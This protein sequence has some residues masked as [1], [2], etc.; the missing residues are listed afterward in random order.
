ME[1]RHMV[2][3]HGRLLA[4][5]T[6]RQVAI[7]SAGEGIPPTG[8]NSFLA[9]LPFVDHG[10]GSARSAVVETR[11]NYGGFSAA[12]CLGG[13]FDPGGE[14]LVVEL[15]DM[16]RPLPAGGDLQV[17]SDLGSNLVPGLPREYARGAFI[18][19]VD[20]AM[21]LPLPSGRLRVD[22]AA[23]DERDSS[24]MAFKMVAGLLMWVLCAHDSVDEVSDG[25]VLDQLA[26]WTGDTYR[27]SAWPESRLPL[28]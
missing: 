27:K 25:T 10:G 11:K 24:L 6:G 8:E 18:G 26:K 20:A 17:T 22:I 21:F 2:W 12:A 14:T 9:T 7:S 5:T 23:H 16:S 15:V 1:A 28:H 4:R 3:G 13:R 19:L